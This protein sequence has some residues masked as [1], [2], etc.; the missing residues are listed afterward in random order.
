MTLG[1]DPEVT[2][3]DLDNPAGRRFREL[4]EDE[5]YVFAP[6]I[7]HALDARLAEMAGHQAVYMSGYSTVL[8]QFGFPDL[9]MVTMTEM[10]ENGKRIAE[11]TSADS[12]T[13]P[14]FVTATFFPFRS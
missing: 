12:V 5:P 3:R 9:E 1:L 14:G 2:T 8:G 6:G 10:V 13:D 4:L 11:A 7:Y